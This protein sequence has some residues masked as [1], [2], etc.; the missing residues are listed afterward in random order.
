MAFDRQIPEVGQGRRSLVVE[1]GDCLALMSRLRDSC[2][3]VVVTSPPYNIGVRYGEYDDR[4]PREEYLSWMASVSRELVRV[5]RKD[6]SVFLNIGSTGADPWIASDVANVFRG[7][8]VL[9]NTISWVKSISIGEETFGHFKPISSRRFLN[10]NHETI[11]HFTRDG[12]ASVD[13]LA[14]GVPFKDKS[15]IARWGHVRDRRCA[16]N[17]WFIPYKTVRS[18]SQKFDHPAGFPVELP[19]RCIKLHGKDDAVVLDPF[20]GTGTT[21]VAAARLGLSGFGFEIDAAYARTARE[22]LARTPP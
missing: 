4:R 2:I 6:G 11:F 21:L 9:Q 20:L 19:E 8:F 16:G 22:R 5:L 14:V 15:N 1:V 13:R 7:D 18:K 12:C 3:D 17:T 10:N